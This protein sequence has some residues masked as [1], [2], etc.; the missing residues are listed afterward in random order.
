MDVGREKGKESKDIRRN[1]EDIGG[2]KGQII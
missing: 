1:R 2:E